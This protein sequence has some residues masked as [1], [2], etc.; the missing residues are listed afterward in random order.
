MVIAG[1]CHCGATRLNVPH[2]PQRATACT[3]TFCT[4][5]GVLWGYYRPDEVVIEADREQRDYAPSGMNHH[6]FC[7]YCGCSTWSKTPDWSQMDETGQNPATRI[8][9]NLWLLED[10]DV[11]DLPVELLD[12]RNLW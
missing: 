11:R 8:A 6:H 7:G 10:V 4:K 2:L 12:G 9:V 5:R 1:S 3:C